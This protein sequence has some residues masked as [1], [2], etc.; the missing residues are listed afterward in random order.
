MEIY[1][2][3]CNIVTNEKEKYRCQTLFN[4]N[5]NI[6]RYE[7]KYKSENKFLT[8]L[9]RYRSDVRGRRGRLL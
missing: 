1:N 8:R 7:I 3:V 4:N 5:Y 9:T 2:N 6:I